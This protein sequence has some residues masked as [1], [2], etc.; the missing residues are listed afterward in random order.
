MFTTLLCCSSTM[1]DL[2]GKGFALKNIFISLQL[3][4]FFLNWVRLDAFSTFFFLAGL[5]LSKRVLLSLF[6][7]CA[8]TLGCANQMQSRERERKSEWRLIT[9]HQEPSC[10]GAMVAG[11]LRNSPG[12][13]CLSGSSFVFSNQFGDYLRQNLNI[14]S[15][16]TQCL[17]L[18]WRYHYISSQ[19]G[20]SKRGDADCLFFFFA[21]S[22]MHGFVFLAFKMCDCNYF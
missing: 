13:F 4:L 21:H 7:I 19:H 2:E 12:Q 5:F 10:R 18:V 15:H 3:F 8:L 6:Y 16:M 9:F 11:F 17:S 22:H 1:T 20:M 14:F